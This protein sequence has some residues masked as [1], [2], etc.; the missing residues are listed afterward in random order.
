MPKREIN[1][2][3]FNAYKV[4]AF[5]FGGGMNGLGVVRNLGRDGVPVYC[6]VERTD[7]VIYSSFCKK[8]YVVPDIEKSTS[9]LRKFLTNFEKL[10]DGG[11]LFSTSDLYSL[12]L[13]ELKEE[14][15]DSYYIPLPS[16]EVVRKLVNKK[17]F[18][19]SLSEFGVPHPVTYFPESPE[20][21][22]RISHE[23]KYPVFIKPDR[24]QEFGLKFH[25]KGFVADSA[26]ELMRY[27]LFALNN[28]I[29]VIFQ[30][31]IPGLAAKNIY[32]I[33][34]YF[35]KD[36]EPKAIFAH[37]RLRGW[38]PMF[39]NTCLRESISI[40]EVIPQVEATNSYLQHIGYHG[41]MEAEWKRDPRDGSFKLLEINARQSMQ[42]VLP[43][44][45]GINLIL[46]A[47]MDA[48]GEK[49]GYTCSYE[50][51]IKW[52]NFLQDLASA[53]ETRT[54]IREWISSLE[55]TREWSYFAVDDI[56]PW[57]VSNC[58]TVREIVERIY[59]RSL[60]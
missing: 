37:R 38:P 15:G 10:K 19:Q 11:V 23:I 46:I 17:E 20:D 2:K 5:V 1:M 4:P 29:D 14:L 22:R 3:K 44:K 26:N 56:M 47:Y 31:V 52:V 7:Q 30:E 9:I 27:Y 32:G 28:K 40:S 42:N 59:S 18:Y 39:G 51:G 16:D 24:S 34:S 43:S 60:A 13:S 55:N 25:K 45:C 21:V 58:E 36:S 33:E 6:I 41:L 8:R 12:H 54:S 57:I 50:K 48:M 49:I 53:T 35:D